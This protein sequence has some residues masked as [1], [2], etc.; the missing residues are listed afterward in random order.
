MSGH[1]HYNIP[2]L[3]G[4]DE[5][6]GVMVL[7]LEDHHEPHPEEE[8]FT[9]MLGRAVASI[10]THRNLE[11][12]ASYRGHPLMKESHDV[13]LGHHEKW[14]GSGYPHGLIGEEIPVF[15]RVCAIADVFDALTTRRPYKE[16]WHLERTLAHIRE[17]SGHHFDPSLVEALHRSLDE[18]L[19]VASLFAGRLPPAPW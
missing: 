14:D 8:T 16:P 17:Q 15:A 5:T 11:A 19:E 12:R 1:G 4:S 13:A 2:L 3:G 9:D 6:I 18:I 7:Y 10:L